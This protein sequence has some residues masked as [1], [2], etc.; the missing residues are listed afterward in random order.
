[1]RA[2]LVADQGSDSTHQVQL[3]DGDRMIIGRG[4]MCDIQILHS[5]L[6]RIQC[7]LIN[8]KGQFVIKDL[9]SR[10]G[11][12]VNGNRITET[13]LS[14]GDEIKLG[15]MKFTF[16]NMSDNDELE[17][18]PAPSSFTGSATDVKE[19]LDP[20]QTSL[21]NLSDEIQS[22]E[23][24]KRVQRDLLTIYRV[25][26]LIHSERDLAI[27]P[28]RIVEA[29]F[30]VISADRCVL[31][32]DEGNPDNPR[33]KAA[34]TKIY[35]DKKAEDS[36]FSRTIA[37]ESFKTGVSILR[38]NVLDDEH[39]AAAESV[40]NQNITSVMCVPVESP[41]KIMGVLYVDTV[42]RS[43]GFRK[44]DLELLAAVGRQAGIALRRMQLQEELRE[45]FYGTVRALVA[46]IE[47][48]DDYTKGHSERVTA[49]ALK[50][51]RKIGL[52]KNDLQ[53][54]ELAC[55][56]HDV[57][58]IGV[59]E[60]VLVKPGPLN[61]EE[62]FIIERH[63]EIG[64]RIIENIRQSETISEIVR[65]HHERY[66]GKG[67]PEHVSGD[68]I[69]LTARILAVADTLDA[70]TSK[71]PYRETPSMEELMNTLRAEQ[72]KQ[73]DAQVAAITLDMLEKGEIIIDAA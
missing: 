22:V 29:I 46:T 37:E 66:D 48:K 61:V 40:I 19:K 53:V 1:M 36:T 25:G 44:H 41:D 18:E 49:Y 65:R 17:K 54:L 59:M 4:E 8:Q 9:A 33:L 73:F 42:G 45:S 68:E 70:M 38:S 27:L 12:W 15:G 13:A 62:R 63:P 2:E 21:M 56:L 34:A 39:F 20:D 71:R 24:F 69:P 67:Y 6:S 55:L 35:T 64:A 10:N 52:S 7:E 11:T 58:K 57:G 16:K 31:I 60:R 47:A 28:E 30:D 23:N 50:I 72:G 43:D 51:G 26:N 3:N 5:G 32:M 14:E